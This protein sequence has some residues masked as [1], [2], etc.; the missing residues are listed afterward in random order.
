MRRI[1]P[2]LVV[3]AL[4]GPACSTGDDDAD[5]RAVYV[6]AA[7]SAFSSGSGGPPLPDDVATCV[8]AAL[9]DLVGSEE[10]QDAG[11]TAQ[12]LAD[13]ADLRSL[14]VDLPRDAPAR[15]GTALGACELGG[16][17]ERPLLDAFAA[18]SG[19]PLSTDAAT[20]V[21]AGADD[22]AIEAGLAET[23]IDRSSG[24]A[25]FDELLDAVG[26]CPDAVAELLVNGFGQ[27]RGA[28]LDAA[29]GACIRAHVEA[30]AEAAGATFTEG[31]A[32]ADAYAAALLEACPDLAAP[33]AA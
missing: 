12:E 18:E 13:A 2:L 30:N 29:L 22:A 1:A 19:A 6:D 4:L 8:G 24:T 27:Q 25:G 32:A 9:V 10:L 21:T 33:P 16:A 11:V 23:F 7:A 28:P 15:L 5:P 26:A 14:D 3:A 20:C 17:V 31:G